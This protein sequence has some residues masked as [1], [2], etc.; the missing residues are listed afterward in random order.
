MKGMLLPARS[1]QTRPGGEA[2]EWRECTVSCERTH[3]KKLAGKKPLMYGACERYQEQTVPG[4][5]GAKLQ[6]GTHKGVKIPRTG[7]HERHN[8]AHWP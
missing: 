6:E 2:T 4:T 1:G 8:E 3:P 7:W 5:F